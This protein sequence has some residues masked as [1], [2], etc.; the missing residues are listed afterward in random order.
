MHTILIAVFNIHF[1]TD[2][3]RKPAAKRTLIKNDQK[4]FMEFMDTVEITQFFRKKFVV[5]IKVS[6]I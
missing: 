6:I 2:T 3:N 1:N 5:I 4:E